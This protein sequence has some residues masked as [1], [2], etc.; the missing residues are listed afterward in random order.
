MCSIVIAQS[1]NIVNE[2]NINEKTI[3]VI[4]IMIPPLTK[5]TIYNSDDN[6]NDNSNSIY[7]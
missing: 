5:I 6:E 2:I 7:F 4:I 3:L 1:N